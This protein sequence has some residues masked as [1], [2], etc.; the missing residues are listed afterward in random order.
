MHN[1]RR[2]N[3]ACLVLLCAFTASLAGCGGPTAEDYVPEASIARQGLEAALTAWKNGEPL[4]TITSLNVPVNVVDER[5]RAGRKLE[6]YEIVS[7]APGEPHRTFTV[8]LRLAGQDQD[9][10]TTYIVTG[11]DP[12]LVFREEDYNVGGM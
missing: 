12:I 8:T 3:S 7:E 6:S 9:E 10:E 1:F 2:V 5:W 4:K 11:L